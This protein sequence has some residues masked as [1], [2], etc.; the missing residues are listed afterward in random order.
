MMARADP[1]PPSVQGART[2]LP[3]DPALSSPAPE[4]GKEWE[5][6]GE[7]DPP[8]R[9]STGAR[10]RDVRPPTQRTSAGRIK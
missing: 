6:R 5:V 7:D 9:A 2:Q 4:A 1:S 8:G 3:S 10:L